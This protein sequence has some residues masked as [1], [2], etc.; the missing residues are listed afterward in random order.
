MYGVH[1]YCNVVEGLPA[2]V[3]Y[4]CMAGI[5]HYTRDPLTT[6][7][8]SLRSIHAIPVMN[9]S[10][11]GK[12]WWIMLPKGNALLLMFN[13][14]A[15]LCRCLCAHLLFYMHYLWWKCP[16]Y[17]A[18][19]WHKSHGWHAVWLPCCVWFGYIRTHLLQIYT[20]FFFRFKDVTVNMLHACSLLYY[21]RHT[22]APIIL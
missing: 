7:C 5:W 4:A 21:P 11:I 6:M 16:L 20:C 19:W 2:T 3:M 14:Q 18:L 10:L 1:H 12:I 9:S 13:V 8:V 22:L 15:A 17:L